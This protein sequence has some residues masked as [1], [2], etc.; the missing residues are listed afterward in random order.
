MPGLPEGFISTHSQFPSV[1]SNFKKDGIAVDAGWVSTHAA[2]IRRNHFPGIEMQLPA[3]QRAGNLS[4][5]HYPLRKRSTFMR[6]LVAQCE[7]F[8]ARR[9][10]Y[11]D[12]AL[13]RFHDTRPE[14]RDVINIANHFP[15]SHSLLRCLQQ[16]A[17]HF[18]LAFKRSAFHI[19]VLPPRQRVPP[20][21]PWRP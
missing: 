1:A 2:D 14:F 5:M 17:R 19:P 15:V 16:Y 7:N 3:V 12:L 20:M 4:A 21:D 8:V 13:C 10:K 6:A 9:A 11:G 18:C